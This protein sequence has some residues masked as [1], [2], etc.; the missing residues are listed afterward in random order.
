LSDEQD[1]R[2]YIKLL[3]NQWRL[4]AGIIVVCVVVAVAVALAQSK[5][6]R[7]TA[8][9]LYSPAE[10]PALAE[11]GTD[12]A[13][14]IATLSGLAQTETVLSTAS[15]R[16]G[17]P[18][19]VLRSSVS[20]SASINGD[21]ID[22][23]ATA[24]SGAVAATR[25]NGVAR[26]LAA[27]RTG[28]A[29]RIVNLEI[30]SLKQQI[31]SLGKATATT[32]L[33]IT[34]LKGQLHAAQGTLKTTTGDVALVEP[35]PVPSAAASPRPALNAAVGFL[36]GLLA[37]ALVL[38]ARD[39]MDRR[40]RTSLELERLW[41]LPV[42]AAIRE[43]GTNGHVAPE[44]ADAFRM[45]RA[46]LMLRAD[47]ELPRVVLVT[48]AVEGEGKSAV[49]ANLS[50]ALAADGR[51]VVAVS[52]DLQRP[53]LQQHLAIASSSGI[54]EVLAD[55]AYPTDVVTR[56]PLLDQGTAGTG[57]LD[58]LGSEPNGED[59]PT[60]LLGR[61]MEHMLEDLQDEYDIVVLDAPPILP[62]S[63]T[64]LLARAPGIRMLVVATIGV[65]QRGDIE[66]ARERLAVA[67][68]EPLGLLVC[69]A[70]AE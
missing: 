7:S 36:V 64:V 60:S 16:I 13:R 14:V 18:I 2:R 47:G 9:L 26:A 17:T 39:R 58:L 54:A 30:S 22:V 15:S 10:S 56:V 46:N 59:T 55:D 63:E 35:A 44:V 67:G 28:Q 69:G 12:P 4:A 41:K 8:T 65:A 32:Q 34:T 5:T 20:A 27:V 33:A 62:A 37:A 53:A 48:S 66:R 19:A 11:T 61:A 51:R 23:T 29:R 40:P 1:I 50:R 42:V 70:D 49:A 21:L 25:A 45:L 3:R 57:S 24:P 52:A 6:Y 68:V 31:A 38:L 43:V